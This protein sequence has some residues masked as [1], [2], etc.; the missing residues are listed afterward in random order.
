[1][2]HPAVDEKWIIHE[3]YYYAFNFACDTFNKK[4]EK[5]TNQWKLTIGANGA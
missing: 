4:E 3:F 5:I 2:K 1:M